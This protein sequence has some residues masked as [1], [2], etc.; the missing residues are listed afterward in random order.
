MTET[1]I[2]DTPGE[3]LRTIRFS[4]MIIDAM[5]LNTDNYALE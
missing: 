5:R 3:Y 2:V 4:R 1:L